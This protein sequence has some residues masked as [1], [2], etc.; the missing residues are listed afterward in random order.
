MPNEQKKDFERTQCFTYRNEIKNTPI[1]PT[2][3]MEKDSN[4]NNSAQTNNNTNGRNDSN[5]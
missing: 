1:P 4:N 3:G 2:A 5:G